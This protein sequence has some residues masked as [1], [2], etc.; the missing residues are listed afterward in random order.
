MVF[1]VKLCSCV[2]VSY[3][4]FFKQSSNF[5]GVWCVY[6]GIGNDST[7][8]TFKFPTISSTNVGTSE[9]GATEAGVEA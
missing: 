7:Y 6:C 1:M 5:H 2:T 8:N 3:L 9:V 4:K